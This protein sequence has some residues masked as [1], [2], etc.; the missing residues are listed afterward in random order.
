LAAY[1]FD[2]PTNR[3][4]DDIRLIIMN[5]VRTLF[6]EDVCTVRREAH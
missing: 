6:S 2:H 5:K 4:D 1:N 3:V